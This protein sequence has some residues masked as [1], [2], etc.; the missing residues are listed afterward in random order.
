MPK[1]LNKC[2]GIKNFTYDMTCLTWSD[3]ITVNWTFKSKTIHIPEKFKL[4]S[5]GKDYHCSNYSPLYN[6]IVKGGYEIRITS[7]FHVNEIEEMLNC[8]TPLMFSFYQGGILKT[9]TF[10]QGAWNK[11]RQKLIDIF[12]LYNYTKK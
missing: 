8:Q 10:S 7:K 12:N 2:E 9:A 1:K 6:D 3:S 4:I 5:C 11:E